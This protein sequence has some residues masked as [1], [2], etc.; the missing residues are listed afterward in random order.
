[1]PLYFDHNATA[2]LRPE[3][4]AAMLAA[5]DSCGNPS[6]IHS[7]GRK[8]SSLIEHA[9]ENVGKFINCDPKGIIFT[10]SCTEANNTVL[11]PFWRGCGFD[12]PLQGLF[13]S[14]VE[15][16][17][18]IQGG[19]FAANERTAIP[20]DENGIVKADVLREMLASR[21]VPPLVSIM[22]ANNET[23]V[24]Q[25]IAELADIV[26]EY[27]GFFH[28]DAAQ[29]FGRI[30]ID[31]QALK[32]DVVTFTAHKAG[33]PLGVGVIAKKSHQFELSDPL[34]KGGGQEKGQR[35]GTQNVV[36]IAGLGAVALRHCEERSDEAI[37]SCHSE[38]SEES[39]SFTSVQD[40]NVLDCRVAF[41]A[42]RNDDLEQSLL[43]LFPNATIFGKNAPRLPNT[44]LFA[45]PN[46]TAEKALM[47]FDLAGV[48][49]SSGSA[50]S[51]GKV[52][53]SHVLK[54]MNVDDALIPCAIR[55]STGWNTT[56]NDIDAFVSIAGKVLGRLVEKSK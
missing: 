42:P 13:Y 50:C 21:T 55:I 35:A 27:N 56:Q 2:P 29:A 11:T 20:V 3:A 46:V 36:A 10:S 44:T 40:D 4:K 34:I 31:M 22:L 38:H 1:M 17:C 25:P 49:L 19:A 12:V 32:A 54:A 37:Q 24:I 26:H 5:M 43:S 52:G 8:A 9:R 45:I 15:H 6:S 47:A 48:A 33:G 51:S 16:S 18:I 53:K 23:G 7:F 28:V 41:Q 14:A 30:P 39:R